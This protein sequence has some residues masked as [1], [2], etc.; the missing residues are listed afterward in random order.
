MTT[1]APS[2]VATVLAP[3]IAP[4]LASVGQILVIWPEHPT[5]T[6]TVWN[7]SG[8]RVVRHAH[9]TPGALYGQMLM[10]DADGIIDLRMRDGQRVQQRTA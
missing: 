8:T 5:H 3:M 9:V 10:L 2:Y 6:I 4:V 7:Q 1:S